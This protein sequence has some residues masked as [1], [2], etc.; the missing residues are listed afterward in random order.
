MSLDAQQLIA[1]LAT[2]KSKRAG[3]NS[4]WDDIIKYVTPGQTLS[5]GVA[6]I[7]NKKR[8]AF[9]DS[10]AIYGNLTLA[11]GLY[12]AL[13]TGKWFGFRTKNKEINEDNEVQQYLLFLR[14]R[15][16]DEMLESNF[17]MQMMQLFVSLS[18]I[19]TPC[20]YIEA[21]DA[22]TLNFSTKHISQYFI[23]EDK[24]ELVDTVFREFS[25]TSRQAVQEFGIENVGKAI[26]ESYRA[27]KYEETF[28]FLHAIYPREDYDSSK[29]DSLNMPVASVYVDIKSKKVISESGYKS[30]PYMVPRWGKASGEIYGTSPS[31]NAMAEIKMVNQMSYT[32][33]RAG[34]KK[35][36]PPVN[37]PD[38]MEGK[39][40]QKPRGVNYYREGQKDRVEEIKA[41]GELN[42]GMELENQ[43]RDVIGRFYFIDLFLSLSRITKQMTV[44]E[45]QQRKQES[46]RIL[47]GMLEPLQKEL[48]KPLIDRS[49]EICKRKGIFGRIDRDENLIDAPEALAGQELQVEYTS[50][51]AMT[52]R[53]DE[54]SS[55][56]ISM[57]S[58]IPLFEAH[59][60]Y[61]DNVDGDDVTRGIMERNGVPA[62]WIRDWKAV[63][64]MREAR[65]AALAQQAM[66]E[67]V[68]QAADIS[69]KLSGK[70][71][72]SSPLKSM[73]ENPAAVEG[74]V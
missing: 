49:F 37:A 13:C 51:L 53:M 50:Q 29:R 48:F 24:D 1:R 27:N 32:I 4:V 62:N 5:S 70:V 54:I 7:G 6:T 46:T 14:D 9:Y 45:V 60:E 47:S 31:A 22:T 55:F 11:S 16:L 15:V 17:G 38:Y 65:E 26:Q 20:V 34:Q 69:Q 42:I 39:V 73:E 44:P 68:S 36:D 21:G 28:T 74:M 72:P 25:Y 59:P 12:G 57:E 33:I 30:F 2:M 43:R 18:S 71:D 10:T 67:K 61:F 64:E 58:L 52:L 3:W 8:S 40:N 41:G 19:G 35:V 56:N 66:A 23:A 63:I